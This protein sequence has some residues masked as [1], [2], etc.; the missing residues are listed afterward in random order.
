M[1]VVASPA[2]DVHAATFTVDHL[3]DDSGQACAAAAGDCSLRALWVGL[4]RLTQ[5]FLS[6]LTLADLVRNERAMTRRI[7]QV[8]TELPASARRTKK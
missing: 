6:E 7:S 5:S 4:D 1:A 8:I 2:G 3:G